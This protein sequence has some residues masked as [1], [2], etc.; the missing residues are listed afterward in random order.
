MISFVL[1]SNFDQMQQNSLTSGKPLVTFVVLAYNQEQFIRESLEGAFSQTYSP[2]EIILSDDHST[3]RTFEIMKKMAANYQGPH[4]IVLNQNLSNLGIIG[5]VNLVFEMATGEIIV[6]S[7]GDDFSIPERTET[8]VAEF[9]DPQ[10]MAV[11]SHLQILT[12]NGE[13]LQVTS[14][15]EILKVI[16]QSEKHNHLRK[17]IRGEGGW[18]Q[19]AGAA[20]RKNLL[21]KYGPLPA[22]SY[23]E[24]VMMSYLAL[25]EGEMRVIQLPLVKYR[26]HSFSIMHILNK[27]RGYANRLAAEIRRC[28]A[29]LATLD[30]FSHSLHSSSF[31]SVT[32]HQ[33]ELSREI[34]NTKHQ[35]ELRFIWLN[36]SLPNQ[37]VS[38]IINLATGNKE[39]FSW[40]KK[41]L[42]HAYLK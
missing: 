3:D 29:R 40:Q 32:K 7:A 26:Q 28:K 4:Q 17:I 11:S 25:L 37:I 24:D 8:I 12:E 42:L 1:D 22:M 20:Y 41:F 18:L 33:D 27:K 15:M 19:G 31:A 35:V 38:I 5:H 9:V 6:G 39:E 16:H 14:D 10:V 36:Q 21:K 23:A 13:S 2:M 30:F 34:S